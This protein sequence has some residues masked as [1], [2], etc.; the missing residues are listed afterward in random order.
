MGQIATDLGE[1]NAGVVSVSDWNT[2]SGAALAAAYDVIVF[3]WTLSSS[4]DAD[5]TTRM[6]P[7]LNAGG[8]VI[9]EDPSNRNELAAGGLTMGGSTS[10]DATYSTT[11]AGLTDSETLHRY[12]HFAMSA[13][14]SDWTVFGRNTS[15][16]VAAVQTF[17]SGGTFIINGSDNFYHGNTSNG[18]YIGA[19]N[20]VEYVLSDTGD[21]SAVP[22][23]A[24]LPLM[25]AG[26]GALGIASRRRK[27]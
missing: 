21:V 5:W 23:P 14:S 18:D 8:N 9:F 17:A 4:V 13:V 15:N 25:L 26:L 24:G 20:M 3:G 22:L 10:G 16:V 2:M 27:S 11:I 1:T 7:Y 6:L 19:R 12:E